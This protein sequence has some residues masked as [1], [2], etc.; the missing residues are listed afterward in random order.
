MGE[1]SDYHND[2]ETPEGA[3]DQPRTLEQYED[4]HRPAILAS[5]ALRTSEPPPA[6]DKPT[7]GIPESQHVMAKRSIFD[8]RR[9]LSQRFPKYE[10]TKEQGGATLT[11]IPWYEEVRLIGHFTNHWWEYEVVMIETVQQNMDLPVMEY[12]RQQRKQVPTGE[13]IQKRDTWIRVK[14]RITVHAYEGSF[15]YDGTGFESMDKQ[16]YG[17]PQSTAE[18]MALR[19]AATK[20]GLGLYLY[21]K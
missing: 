10:K 9:D 17:D 5:A 11:F 1:M 13:R 3:A 8:I 14:V 12:D 15:S 2:L 6:D 18:S 4:G 21:Q 19:R 20:L 16:S 7:G